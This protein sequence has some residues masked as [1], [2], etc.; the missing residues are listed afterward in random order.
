MNADHALIADFLKGDGRPLDVRT[1]PYCETM[2]VQIVAMD[3]EAGACT[4]AFDP[5][6]EFLQAAGVLQG[7]IVASMLDT[8]IAFATIAKLPPDKTFGTVSLSVNFLKGGQIGRY[9]SRAWLNRV[10]GRMIFGAAELYRDGDPACV[11]TAQAAQ[12]VSPLPAAQ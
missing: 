3:V 6:A 5:G 8:A 2:R 7:G 1:S 11:A 10:G 12:A 9:Q 4:L